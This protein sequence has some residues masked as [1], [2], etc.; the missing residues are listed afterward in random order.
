MIFLEHNAF[1]VTSKEQSQFMLSVPTQH[2]SYLPS[3]IH[4]FTS[5]DLVTLKDVWE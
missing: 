4:C 1:K 5:L 2:C 3:L